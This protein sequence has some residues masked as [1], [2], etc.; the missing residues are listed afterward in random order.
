[1]CAPV[2]RTG[3]G[4]KPLVPS[5]VPNLQLNF[6]AIEL[7]GFEPEVNSDGGEEDLAKFIIR[8]SDND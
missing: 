7:K 8:V 1:M 3:N 4:A 2:V 5:C 6:V